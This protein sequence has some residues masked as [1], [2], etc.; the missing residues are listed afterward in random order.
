[1]NVSCEE[2]CSENTGGGGGNVFVSK[3]NYKIDQ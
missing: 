3:D 2:L 1:M